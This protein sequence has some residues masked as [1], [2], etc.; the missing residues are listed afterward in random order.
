MR[1]FFWKI[2]RVRLYCL[3]ILLGIKK[4][5]D[6]VVEGYFVISKLYFY[7]FVR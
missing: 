1:V 5:F 4:K 2:V 3:N 6:K 7:V